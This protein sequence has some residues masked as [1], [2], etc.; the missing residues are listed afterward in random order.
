MDHREC[1]REEHKNAINNNKKIVMH[2][3]V[4]PHEKVNFVF[5]LG[6]L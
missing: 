4:Q 1:K 5:E 2:T 6:F 3:I